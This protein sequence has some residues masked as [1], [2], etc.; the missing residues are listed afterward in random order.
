[1]QRT[2]SSDFPEHIRKNRGSE[3]LVSSTFGMKSEMWFIE[4]VEYYVRFTELV[5]KF[6]ADIKREVSMSFRTFVKFSKNIEKS[7]F[8]LK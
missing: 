2:L 6:R 1:M 7:S 3:G 4:S 5:W 8:S